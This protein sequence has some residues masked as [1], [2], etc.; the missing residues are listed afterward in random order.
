MTKCVALEN[1]KNGINVNAICP[2]V[3]ET[4]IIR[5]AQQ[6]MLETGMSAGEFKA[7]I[8]GQIPMGRMLQ[9]DEIA[10]IATYLASPESNGMTG[11]TIT[12]SGGMRMG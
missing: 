8:E 2:G 4:D 12:I 9:P 3:V 5:S 10:P 7:A 6:K 11:Q 1:A